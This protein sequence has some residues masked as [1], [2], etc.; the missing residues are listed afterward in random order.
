I[1]QLRLAIPGGAGLRLAP[2]CQI[3][4]LNS[5]FFRNKG[6]YAVGRL[7]NQGTIYPFAIALLRTPSGH[8]QLDALLHTADDLS[9][10]FSFTRAYF[11]VDME[12]PA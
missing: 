7:V 9:T 2:D 1:H 12:T 10:L 8:I 3:H 11:L 5:L 4:V 6:A